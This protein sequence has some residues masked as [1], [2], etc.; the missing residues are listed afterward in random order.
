[1]VSK[2]Q[3]AAKLKRYSTEFDDFVKDPSKYNTI[4]RS[5]RNSMLK[6][7]GKRPICIKS[8]HYSLCFNAN[9]VYYPIIDELWI[10]SFVKRLKGIHTLQ[11]TEPTNPQC[12]GLFRSLPDLNF[13][14]ERSSFFRKS[15][16]LELIQSQ[17]GLFLVVF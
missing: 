10:I 17:I 8:S 6:P 15:C 14:K 7:Q 9:T 11:L 13:L 2:R 3:I 16:Q 5:G 12:L 4:K 1:M